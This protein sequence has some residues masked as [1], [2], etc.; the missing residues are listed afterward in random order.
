MRAPTVTA[1]LVSVSARECRLVRLAFA[2]IAAGIADHAFAQPEAGTSAADHLASGLVP[3]AL[4]AIVAV[5]YPRL[6]AGLR[7]SLSL[8]IGALTVLAGTLDGIRHVVIDGP[9]AGDW[10]AIAA[11]VAGIG[12]L[13]VGLAT[14]WRSRRRDEYPLRRYA[15]RALAGVTVV[16]VA[17]F[18][19]IPIGVAILA[20]HRARDDV[21][22][23]DFGL[24]RERVTLRT[25]DGLQLAGWYVP[26]RNRAAMIVVPGRVGP[27]PNARLLVRHGYGVLLFDRRGEGESEGDFNAFGWD[28]EDDVRAAIAFLQ[29]RADVDPRRIGSLGLSV[30]GE[31]LLQ[32]AAHTDA[33]RAVVSEG[34][35]ARSLAEQ[36]ELPSVPAW[37]RPLSPWVVQTAAVA[38]LANGAPPRALG[39]L[40][41]QVRAPLLLIQ[42]SRGHEDEGL[43]AVYEAHARGAVS[44]WVAPGGHTG[45]FATNPD[46]YERRVIDFLDQALGV[47]STTRRGHP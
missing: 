37:R 26:S 45:A 10:T 38:V 29:H 40:V 18:V 4:L 32:T 47:R 19:V 36:L 21:P 46:E 43:N 12:L 24:A 3:L 33:L 39:D 22:A 44:R 42:A 16:V 8:L 34:A 6:R 23:A 35:G 15:R 31:I 1:T 20:T 27:V 25:A 30:G 17:T 2:V 5:T 13:V 14:L 11:A 28:G 9:A 7:A 41:A